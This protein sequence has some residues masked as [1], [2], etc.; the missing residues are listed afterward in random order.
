MRQEGEVGG[1][2]TATGFPPTTEV[3]SSER[4]I[5]EHPGEEFK[6]LGVK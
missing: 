1:R 2:A 6:L 5:F 3:T 4:P